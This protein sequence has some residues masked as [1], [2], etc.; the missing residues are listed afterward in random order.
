MSANFFPPSAQYV[1]LGHLHRPQEIASPSPGRYSGSPLQL[2]F[3]EKDDVKSVT[4]VEV[5]AGKRAKPREVPL[6]A[7]RRLRVVEGTRS[8]LDRLEPT[9]DWLRVIVK[10]KATPGLADEIRS[11]FPT[12]V[13]VTI[14]ST[15][16]QPPPP[17]PPSGRTPQGLVR[18]YLDTRNVETEALLA[19]F[20]ELYDEAEAGI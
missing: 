8:Q 3:G 12:A 13:D 5:T 6:T 9:E 7:G 19:L 15:G 20:S 17:P 14:A 11:L 2:D 18:E 16:P 1:A 4:V 10:E